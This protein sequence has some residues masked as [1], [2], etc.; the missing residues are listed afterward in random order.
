V[1]FFQIST[2]LGAGNLG[3]EV[4]ARAFWSRLP[5]DWRLHVELFPESVRYRGGYPAEHQYCL[6]TDDGLGQAARGGTPAL[7][8]CGTPINEAEG[9]QYPMQFVAARLD[10]FH[11]AGTPVDAVGVGVDFLHSRRAQTLFHASYAPL[12]TWTVRTEEC[13]EALLQAPTGLGCT[14]LSAT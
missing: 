11:R 1:Q 9:L 2:G 4:M 5:A 8:A 7:L 14:G 6:V 13:R 10:E 3:D 12:R